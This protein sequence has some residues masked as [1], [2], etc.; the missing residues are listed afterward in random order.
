[1]P[2]LKDLINHARTFKTM[3][4][5]A[6]CAALVFLGT[7][8]PFYINATSLPEAVE[9][10]LQH[11]LALKVEQ[12]ILL[13]AND[14]IGIDR[15][16][17]LPSLYGHANTT[18]NDD[19]YFYNG[20]PNNRA[21]YNSHGYGLSFRQALIDF[22]HYY[23]YRQAKLS[24]SIAE[25]R[26][27]Q[28]EQE[29]IATTAMLYF[30]YL[31]MSADI[32]N[33]QMELNSSIAREKHMARN[34][35]LGNK[36]KNDIYEVIAQ[37][38]SIRTRLRQGQTERAIV[39]DEL[40]NHIQFPITP[41]FDIKTKAKLAPLDNYEQKQVRETALKFN[42]ALLISQR[43]VKLSRQVLKQDRAAFY[44]TLDVTAQ[45]QHSDSNNYDI[46]I[47]YETGESH[48]TKVA[49]NLRLPLLD[50]GRDYYRY[51]QSK[52]AIERFELS[53]EQ[54]LMS[55]T[56]DVNTAMLNL[57]NLA[58]N[59]NSYRRIL[60]ANQA[61]YRGIQRAYE[62]GTRTITDVLTAE[63]RVFRSQRDFQNAR[64][65][66]V[67]EAIQLEKLSGTLSLDSIYAIQPLMVAVT[68][69]PHPLNNPLSVPANT[70]NGV[71]NE[72]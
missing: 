1:M 66:Y 56:Q 16:P 31:K 24:F 62:L 67:N 69:R 71:A 43:N 22:G 72:D 29:T 57:N 41:S 34:I 10:G 44:P 25:M 38:E 53:H 40:I 3:R 39:L 8:A 28:V 60:Q 18:W 12:K 54:T 70:E 35:E 37:K 51:Q 23:R 6:S 59:I 32:E 63:N 58:D 15:A 49:L 20:E 14:A 30:D 42:N 64:Y 17:L 50:G 7:L 47:P 33:H 19:E 68:S 9:L 55:T 4:H 27:Q 26:Y 45:Y 21:Q 2:Q 46:N 11:N 13:E 65:D 48:S 52:T 5:L 61:A 36:A